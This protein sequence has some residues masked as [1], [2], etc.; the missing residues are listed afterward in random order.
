MIHL[1]YAIKGFATAKVEGVLGL[2]H[3]VMDC[4]CSSRESLMVALGHLN[5]RKASGLMFVDMSATNKGLWLRTFL[6]NNYH[7]WASLTLWHN[8]F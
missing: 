8:I 1:T 6:A 4:S 5:E 2:Y 7:M 3:V